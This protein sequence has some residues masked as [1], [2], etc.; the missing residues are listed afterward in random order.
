MCSF[1]PANV[2]ESTKDQLRTKDKIQAAVSKSLKAER[3][4]PKRTLDEQ[5]KR[6][7]WMGAKKTIN[8]KRP[9]SIV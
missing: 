7:K 5:K 8:K 3:G 6:S 4:K 1:V 2:G 9:K